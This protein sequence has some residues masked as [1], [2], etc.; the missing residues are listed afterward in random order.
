MDYILYYTHMTLLEAD[1]T[2][3]D[4]FCITGSAIPTARM[5]RVFGSR[6]NTPKPVEELIHA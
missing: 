6:N 3:I 2:V 1:N 5:E 4:I